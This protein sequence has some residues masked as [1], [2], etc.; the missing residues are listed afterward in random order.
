MRVGYNP[1]KDKEHKIEDYLHQIVIPVFIPNLEGYFSQ[2]LQVFE[3][4]LESLWATVHEKTFITIVNNGSCKEV[5]EYIDTN[6]KNGKIH[7]VIHT[8]NVGKLNSVLKGLVGHNFPL[9]TISDSDV[10]FCSGWQQATSDVFINFPK[11]GVVGLTPQFKMFENGCGNVIAE[12][13]F[14][15]VM[16]FSK[17][18]NPK[19]LELFY[20]SIGWDTNYNHDY[21][22]YTLAISNNQCEALI[23]TGHFVATYKKSLFDEVTSYVGYKM[24]GNSEGYLDVA[25]LQKGL[26]RLCTAENYAYH[27]GNVPEDWMKDELQRSKA[28][29][30]SEPVSFE[31][32]PLSSVSSFEYLLKHRLFAKIFSN[33]RFKKW[34][35]IL[36]GL[37]KE[38]ID[39]Y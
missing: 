27:M 21:L 10:L 31:T 17:V 36:K 4:C 19:A 30:H 22:K 24:G 12:N 11:A 20:E 33:K 34:F 6:H 32:V 16:Q 5:K 7:E 13:L 37:P 39:N 15:K 1:H 26:W 3:Y 23:G 35:Y 8:V 9:V 18:K 38:M 28:A 14:S 29:F 2:S 25:P